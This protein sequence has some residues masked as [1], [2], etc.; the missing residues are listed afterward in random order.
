MWDA[1]GRAVG[2]DQGHLCAGRP[3][4]RNVRGSQNRLFL[5]VPF[6]VSQGPSGTEWGLWAEQLC[7]RTQRVPE[8][9][10]VTNSKAQRRLRHVVGTKRLQ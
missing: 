3:I 1:C 5:W 9:K 2:D 10:A 7:L 6:T 8:A 4:E